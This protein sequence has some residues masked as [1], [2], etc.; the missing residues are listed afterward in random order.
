MRRSKSRFGT[1]VG[2][3]V[4]LTPIWG[5]MVLTGRC[6]SRGRADG[7][8]ERESV[9]VSRVRMT[10][11]IQLNNVKVELVSYT[12]FWDDLLCTCYVTVKNFCVALCS[13]IFDNICLVLV[14]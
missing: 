6:T 2:E 9:A 5:E 4:Q 8:S 14:A 1:A 10:E 13:M 7:S 11:Q 3:S 12:G